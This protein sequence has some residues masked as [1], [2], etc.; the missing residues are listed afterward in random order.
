MPT[1]VGADKHP[2]QVQSHL[3]LEINANCSQA[4]FCLPSNF[5]EAIIDFFTHL[6]AAETS[7]QQ[8]TD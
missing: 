6:G 7:C 2:Q 3:N 1:G 8:N 5:K 4:R